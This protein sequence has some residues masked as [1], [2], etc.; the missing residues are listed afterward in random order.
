MAQAQRRGEVRYRDRLLESVLIRGVSRDYVWFPQFE[1]ERGRLI[2]PS[3]VDRKRGVTVLG[4]ATADRLFGQMDPIDRLVKIQGVHFRVIG[5]SEPKG[6]V[7]G[8][9]Q[10]EFAIIPSV[11]TRNCSAPGSHSR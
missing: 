7:F 5:V 4:W 6:S 8:R 9:S 10:D 11:S 1:A 2:T 3:E